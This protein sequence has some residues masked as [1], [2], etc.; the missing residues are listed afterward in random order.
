MTKLGFV[1]DFCPVCVALRT[2]ALE[3]LEADGDVE[4]QRVCV[5]CKVA[6]R[7][8]PARYARIAPQP[9][10]VDALKAA[11]FPDLEQVHQAR[12]DLEAQLR[13]DPAALDSALRRQL[14]REPLTLVAAHA[15]SHP[16]RASLQAAM[17]PLLRHAI[18][19]MQPGTGELDEVLRELAAAGDPAGSLFTSTAL[20]AGPAPPSVNP[21]APPAAAMPASK[22][23]P[24]QAALVFRIFAVIGTLL[25]AAFMINEAATDSLASS[26]NDGFVLIGFSVFLVLTVACWM[27]PRALERRDGWARGLGLLLAFLFVW[28]VPIGTIAG[29]FIGYCLIARWGDP[30]SRPPSMR[31]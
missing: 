2:C 8:D 3:R 27:L 5:A 19:R 11:T 23:G 28:M 10:P 30:A 15:A 24:E 17:L 1:A 21:Y 14:L 25:L 26:L 12:L 20:L 31:M 7:A 13:A 6:V 9:G 29:L 16:D 22:G 4:H 18:G